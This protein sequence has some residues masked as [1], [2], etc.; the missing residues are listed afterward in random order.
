M[1][2]FLD[3]RADI[4]AKAQCVETALMVAIQNDHTACAQLLVD[5]RVS[6]T[7]VAERNVPALHMTAYLDH[8]A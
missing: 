5:V 1:Q 4:E 6:A 8:A 3:A 2:A 7:A